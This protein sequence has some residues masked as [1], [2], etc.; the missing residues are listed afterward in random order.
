[1]STPSDLMV[2]GDFA[3]A[4]GLTPKALRLYDELDLLRPVEVDPFNGYR[5]YAASQLD[6]ARLVA[7]LR[8]A[9]VGLTDIRGVIGQPND[10]VA[11]AVTSFARQLRAD[12]GSRSA[13]LLLLAG[14]LSGQEADMSTTLTTPTPAVAHCLAQGARELQLD[15]LR[16][17]GALH[18][19]ADG[20]GASAAI[21]ESALAALDVGS[22]TGPDPVAALDAAFGSA[23]AVVT[24]LDAAGRA[25]C[26][27]TALVIGADRVFIGHLGDSR[28]YRVREGRLELLTRDHTVTQTLVDEGRLTTEEARHDDRR[29]QLNR[30]VAAGVAC[31]PD[32]AVHT[33]HPGDR[34]VLTTDGVHG[35]LD[36]ADLATLLLDPGPPEAVV[37]TVADAVETHGADDNY[38]VVVVDA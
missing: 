23:Q 27:L 30:A 1:M 6:D 31:E 9:G 22:L 32:L 26:T 13:D 11:A 20:F 16:S 7:A 33:L 25:G 8:R 19:V 24:G 17:E 2:I 28:C 10:V 4:S 18:A 29:V 38:S 21:A 5:R 14:R 37:A 36:P 12:A 35:R 15:A 3:R 34:Y